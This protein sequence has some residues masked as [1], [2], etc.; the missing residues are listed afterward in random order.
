MF[1]PTTQ[2][3]TAAV[4]SFTIGILMA[5][6]LTHYLYKYHAWKKKPGKRSLDGSPAEGFNK[7][8]RKSVV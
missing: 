3:L 2:V 4:L 7:L 1:S 6:L 8:D 5:P